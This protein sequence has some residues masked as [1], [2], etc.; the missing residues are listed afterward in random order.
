MSVRPQ[1]AP[2]TALEE[3]V[4]T[5][6]A[7]N[8]LGVARYSLQR[9]IGAGLLPASRLGQLWYVKRH[10]LVAFELPPGA[11]CVGRRGPSTTLARER[12]LALIAEHPGIT[13][14]QLAELTAE[15]RR[16]ALLRL[17]HLDR[18]GLITRTPQ[19][20]PC[21][22]WRCELTPAGVEAYSQIRS[23]ARCA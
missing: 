13:V 8:Y 23:E 4:D 19:A 6:T 22:Q 16:T 11:H 5:T 15:P 12:A 7:A 10:D 1:R 3:I 21:E 18:A 2:T 14:T 9:Y 20:N 17:Q